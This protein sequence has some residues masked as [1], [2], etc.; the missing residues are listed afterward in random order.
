MNGA[1]DLETILERATSGRQ[2]DKT[3]VFKPSWFYSIIED[4]F[5]IWCEYHAA[6]K[7]RVE[8]TTLFDEH[9]MQLGNEWEDEYVAE[10]FP[11]AHV[12]ESRWGT[13]AL[14]ETVQAM[15][16]G[17]ATIHGAALW[18]LG[19][20]VYG[21]AD[22]L[23]RCDDHASD[24]GNYHYRVQEVKNSKEA[25]QYHQLQAAV[26]T[27]IL[28]E[29]QGY[30]PDSFDIV[31]R[32]GAG[33]QTVAFH[34]VADEMHRYL[35]KWRQIRD[36]QLKPDPRGYN[37]TPSPWRQYANLIVKERRDVSLLPGVGLK[38]A[39]KMRGR[40]ISST[41]E[42]VALGVDGC[43]REFRG[44]HY[45]YHALAIREGKPLFRPGE[46]AA[47]QRRER[48]VYF[49]V[50]DTST[51]DGTIVTRP[52]VY[53]LGVAT[54]DDETHI[55]TAHGED[56]EA[57][58]WSDFL[59]WLGD[60]AEVALYCWTMYED[61]KIRQAASDHPHLKERLMAASASL[62]DLKEEVKHRPYF[63]TTSYSIK[64]L[65]PICGFHW[66]QGDVD[67]LS[68]QL[69]Y[70]DWLKSGDDAAIRRVEQYNR[71]DVLAML[72]VDR[73]VSGMDVADTCRRA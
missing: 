22:L 16:R 73:Y 50:E 19:E 45:Y 38:T 8:E 67:G 39:A 18:L 37:S 26:Y 4:P 1:T 30:R 14:H 9:R 62:I 20:D 17:E 42:I 70:L 27:W 36:G 2:L 65:A 56:D 35:G 29:L 28:A 34:A 3:R 43:V 48:L 69:I 13:P 54:P 46:S 41:E 52:H 51:L 63:P 66:S 23:V 47:I 6:A 59:D 58:M 40:G 15:L 60:P 57:R 68:A 55:F 53:M 5:G 10:N 32:R 7:D 31:L 21:K 71:E 64:E 12:I 33:Q 49:D 72:A 61:G 11:K 24:L 25:K 44:D